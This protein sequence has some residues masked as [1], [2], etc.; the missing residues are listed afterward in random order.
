MKVLMECADQQ[1]IVTYDEQ[2]QT[3]EFMFEPTE[4]LKITAPE[5]QR[6]MSAFLSPARIRVPSRISYFDRPEVRRIDPRVNLKE[7][8]IRYNSIEAAESVLSALANRIGQNGLVTVGELN[9]LSGL[10]TS[11]RDY[12]DYGVGWKN[13]DEFSIEDEDGAEGE[14][15]TAILK[16]PIP[17]EF[18]EKEM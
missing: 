14:R 3:F 18:D 12:R 11:F 13:L 8:T 15:A 5:L 16:F 6:V 2:N 1:V 9:E 7:R 17:V 10:M 4:H